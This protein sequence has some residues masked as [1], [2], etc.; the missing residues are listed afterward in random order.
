MKINSRE[1]GIAREAVKKIRKLSGDM[2]KIKLMHVCGTHEYAITRSGIRALL[3]G[4]IEVISGPGCPVC[5]T[6]TK[7]IDEAVLLSREDEVI[8]TTFGDMLTVPGSNGSLADAKAD[9]SD[10]RIVYSPTDATK[11]ALDNPRREVIHIAI[12]F[13]TTAPTTAYEL[14]DAPGNFSILCCHRTIPE[15]MD[16]LL[17]S[18]DVNVQGFIDPGHVSAIIGVDAY[19]PLSERYRIPQVIAGFEAL[20][21]LLGIF[22]LLHMIRDDIYGVRNEYTRV[23]GDEGNIKALEV[24]RQVFR[25]IDV[26]W[27]GFPVIPGSGLSLRNEFSVFDARKRFDVVAEEAR[28]P[29][30]CRCGDVLKGLIYP[31]E[32]GLF[33]EVCTPRNPVGP[34]MVSSE[35]SCAIAY[36]YRIIH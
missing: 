28:D 22:M 34:C 36:R 23:V 10:I 30:G 15:A 29:A 33:E 12:G 11:I 3:P 18:C 5:V 27:R 19:R 24:M 2:G 7:E 31:Q 9:G 26:R 17:S 35:G 13:E 16:S 14:I 21:V 4:N 20:D 8:V 25:K 32:C 6:T 1:K